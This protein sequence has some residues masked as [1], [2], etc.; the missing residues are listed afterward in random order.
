[1]K[2]KILSLVLAAILA[3]TFVATTAVCAFAAGASLTVA[4]VNETSSTVTVAVGISGNPGIAALGVSLSFD[5][6]LLS[7]DK[8]EGTGIAKEAGMAVFGT[9]VGGSVRIVVEEGSSGDGTKSNGNV[10]LV[11]FKKLSTVKE[12]STA[13]FTASSIS[14]LTYGTDGNDVEIADG[15]VTLSL[16]KAETTTKKPVATT[17]KPVATTK[18]PVATTKKPVATTKKPVTTKPNVVSPTLPGVTVPTTVPETTTEEMTTEE[19]TTEEWTTEYESYSYTAPEQTD[20]DEGDE[21]KSENTKRI[22]AVIVVVVCVGAAAALY[23]TR[24]K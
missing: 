21:N 15:S 20:V 18:K 6:S 17:K 3:F 22:V 4:K 14:S 16:T 19:V 5:S 23:F 11:T 1:M 10:C 12:G 9:D 8:T 2:K 13:N 24:K 7:Y